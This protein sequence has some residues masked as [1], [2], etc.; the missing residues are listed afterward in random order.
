MNANACLSW[1]DGDSPNLNAAR[2][3]AHRIIRDGNRAG[4][5]IKRLRALFKKTGAANTALDLNEAIRDVLGLTRRELQKT[6]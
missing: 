5:V 2:D 3:A 1:L 4:E 6:R